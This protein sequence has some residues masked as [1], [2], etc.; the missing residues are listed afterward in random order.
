MSES[1]ELSDDSDCEYEARRR[2]YQA[3]LFEEGVQR[4]S[5]GR[6]THE[7]E[8]DI[9]FAE[10][11]ALSTSNSSI[12]EK[13]RKSSRSVQYNPNPN[14]TDIKHHIQKRLMGL[15]RKMKDFTHYRSW[16]Y[17]PLIVFMVLTLLR[18][19][20]WQFDDQMFN[21]MTSHDNL[22]DSHHEPSINHVA[23]VFSFFQERKDVPFLW[24][25]PFST[26][27]LSGIIMK[28]WSHKIADAASTFG[29]DTVS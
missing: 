19:S 12:G 22:D 7:N 10:Q 3:I 18:K 27:A 15:S 29:F 9:Q 14:P 24:T 20:L 26:E 23:D 25:I 6:I 11:G 16:W 28:C 17:T 21:Y 5:L 2:S 13:K 1:F 8:N 4:T